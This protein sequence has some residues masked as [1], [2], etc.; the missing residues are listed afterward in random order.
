MFLWFVIPYTISRLNSWPVLLSLRS[1]VLVEPISQVV[2]L[3]NISVHF[4]ISS[5]VVSTIRRSQRPIYINN[6][7][8]NRVFF[9]FLKKD[10]AWTCSY[11]QTS[12][13]TNKQ[14][15]TSFNMRY[16][17]WSMRYSHPIRLLLA[18][19]APQLARSQADRVV[20]VVNL[21]VQP[22]ELLLLLFN[23]HETVFQFPK[24]KPHRHNED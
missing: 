11:F 18:P 22:L 2:V 14:T 8:S 20:H 19:L 23:R 13:H 1:C 16:V 24:K 6:N 12:T 15:K 7:N 4:A 10:F 17:A 3:P 5:N 9:F 21:V